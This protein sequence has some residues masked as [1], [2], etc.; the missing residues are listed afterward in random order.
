MKF[1]A[2]EIKDLVEKIEIYENRKVDS[3]IKANACKVIVEKS[4]RRLEVLLG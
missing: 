2:R 4:K 3:E 1:K